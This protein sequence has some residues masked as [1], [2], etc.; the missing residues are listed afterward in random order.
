MKTQLVFAVMRAASL[1]ALYTVSQNVIAAPASKSICDTERC[2]DVIVILDQSTDIYRDGLARDSFIANAKAAYGAVVKRQYQ[3][4]LNGA[5]LRIPDSHLAEIKR[6]PGVVD[7]VPDDIGSLDATQVN[8]PWGLDRLDQRSNAL[9]STYVY[10]KTGSGVRIHI[11]DTGIRSTH[12]DFGGRV[13]AGYTAI[14]DGNGTSDCHGH[15]THV[16]GTAAGS[17]YGVAKAATIVPVRVATCSGGVTASDVV[18]GLDWVLLN[19][20]L[21]AVV[22]ISL[23]FWGGNSAVDAAV[24][25]VVA[26]GI[27]VVVAAGNHNADACNVSPARVPAAITVGA[28]T[29]TSARASFSNYGKCLDLFAPGDNILSAGHTSNSASATMNGTSMASPHV[30]GIAALYLEQVPV[31]TPDTVT[32]HVVGKNSY[33]HVTSLGTGSPNHM[34]YSVEKNGWRAPLYRYY[35]S[36]DTDSNYTSKWTELQAGVATSY[37][38]LGIIGYG[39]TFPNEDYRELRRLWNPTLKDHLLTV[40]AS[41]NPS[42]Y[43]SDSNVG[44]CNIDSSPILLYRYWSSTYSNH[45]YTPSWAELGTGGSTYVYEG[46][47]CYLYDDI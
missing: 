39:L 25:N 13:V 24:N 23:Q 26:G 38:Y 15:G 45:L 40:D 30:A 29:S 36:A 4:A 8:P 1:V 44:Y 17:S 35:S 34:A 14:A 37:S 5:A 3:K 2:S 22:N 41:E 7:V 28:T 32:N 11:V 21:P 20:T 19:S 46:V 9:N 33:G 27:S 6:L 18:A 42:G 12:A 31:A 43:S 47:E 10:T 16:A